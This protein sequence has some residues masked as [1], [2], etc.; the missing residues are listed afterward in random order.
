MSRIRGRDTRPEMLVRRT[1]HA[2]G[3]RYR[4]HAKDLPGRPDLVFPKKRIALFV[5]GCFW[6]RH[7]GCRLAYTPKS[8]Q[9]FWQSKFDRNVERD[10]E[11]IAGLRALGWKPQIIWEC[12]T[13]KPGL[14]D[15][16]RMVVENC[17]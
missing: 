6:H 13:R 8:N 17:P 5:H 11:V 12:Q 1:A 4:L 10:G 16:L 3:Y 14:D 15:D 2:L 9:Q 7:P